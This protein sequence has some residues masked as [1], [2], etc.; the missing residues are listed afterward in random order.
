MTQLPP[1][2]HTDRIVRRIERH[3]EQN[4]GAITLV[5]QLMEFIMAN[6]QDA[7]N[8]VAKLK[9]AIVDDQASDQAVVD[10]LDV[11]IEQLKAGA[12]TS[13]II[14]AIQDAQSAITAV[15]SPNT[16]PAPQQ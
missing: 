2:H 8:E 12:D 1:H 7:L 11:V 9:Q 14:A 13:T 16:P 5:T 3:L 10:S 4:Q 15:K 6:T